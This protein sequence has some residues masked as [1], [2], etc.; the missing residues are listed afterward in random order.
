MR[1]TPA[2]LCSLDAGFAGYLAKPIS[3]D[4]LIVLLQRLVPA[5]AGTGAAGREPCRRWHGG[6]LGHTLR[7]GAAP[8]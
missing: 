1:N 7:S 8:G 4:K 3:L 5:S 6:L 2:C